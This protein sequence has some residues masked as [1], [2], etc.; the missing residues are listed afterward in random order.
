LTFCSTQ[1]PNFSSNLSIGE[2][3]LT[4]YLENLTTAYDSNKTYETKIISFNDQ[5]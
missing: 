4:F 2:R 3:H 1:L 5:V